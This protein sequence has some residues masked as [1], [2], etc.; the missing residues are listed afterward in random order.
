MCFYKCSIFG[1]FKKI[2]KF[3]F[4]FLVE[5]DENDPNMW[6]CERKGNSTSLLDSASSLISEAKK[7]YPSKI[8]IPC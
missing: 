1:I 8:L 4:I 5:D 7:S 3:V 2:V 6:T